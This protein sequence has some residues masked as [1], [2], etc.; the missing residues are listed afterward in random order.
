M[1]HEAT[2]KKI[3]ELNNQTYKKIKTEEK[4]KFLKRLYQVNEG[5]RNPIFLEEATAIIEDIG[6]DAAAKAVD[7]SIIFPKSKVYSI[8]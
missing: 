3:R 6:Q 5:S 8:A 7:T 1:L 2:H 4:L